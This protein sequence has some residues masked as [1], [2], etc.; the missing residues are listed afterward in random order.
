MMIIYIPWYDM[1]W[2]KKKI[3]IGFEN[4]GNG[5]NEANQIKREREKERKRWERRDL[6]FYVISTFL[7]G[8]PNL[9]LTYFCPFRILFFFLPF[10]LEIY[11]IFLKNYDD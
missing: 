6:P 9:L 4:W 5:R 7:Y 8:L 1:I 2:S 11:S 3:E 10:F